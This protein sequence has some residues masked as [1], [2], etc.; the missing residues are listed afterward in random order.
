[1]IN[2][3]QD[4]FEQV[5]NTIRAKTESNDH[6][7]ALHSASLLLSNT[8]LS[9]S[10]H[11]VCIAHLADREM[12]PTLL[13]YREEL[14]KRIMQAGRSEHGLKLWAIIEQAF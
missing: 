1:M 2:E 9:A 14:R 10:A 13:A 11:A 4:L 3:S 12:R 5:A 7:G 8:D 6:S